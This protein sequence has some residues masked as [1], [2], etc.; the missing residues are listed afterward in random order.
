[1]GPLEAH[2]REARLVQIVR[3]KR[4]EPIVLDPPAA[5]SVFF[6]LQIVIPQGPKYTRKEAK[7]GYVPLEE[8]LLRLRL[9]R[10]HKARARKARLHQ[11]QPHGHRL[12][13]DDHLRLAPVDR[14]RHPRIVDLRA[15]RPR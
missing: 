8:C 11:E 1:V 13:S 6:A 5:F 4:D 2:Q 12:A 15:V 9:K 7:D 14:G 3:T 10:H